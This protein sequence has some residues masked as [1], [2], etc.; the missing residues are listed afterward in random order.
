M[1]MPVQVIA[2][3]R[4]D[5]QNPPILD[6]R[7]TS[8]Q[9]EKHTLTLRV[10]SMCA[11]GAGVVRLIKEIIGVG[12]PEEPMQYADIAEWQNELLE[13]HETEAG[14]AYWNV[15][16]SGQFATVPFERGSASSAFDPREHVLSFPEAQVRRLE[17]ISAEYGCELSS[18]LLASWQ[19]LLWRLDD[20]PESVIGVAF[21]GRK[22]EDLQ[23]TPGPLTRFLPV[24]SSLSWDTP[25]AR[26]TKNA[27]DSMRDA[28]KWQEFFDAGRSIPIAFE[29]DEVPEPIVVG[30][31]RYTFLEQTSCVDRFKV[32][33]CCAKAARQLRITF[34]YDAALVGTDDIERLADRFQTLITS[35]IR[36]PQALAGELDIVGEGEQRRLLKEFTG[37]AVIDRRYRIAGLYKCGFMNCSKS[38]RSRL[39]ILWQSAVPA[40]L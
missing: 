17:A 7:I 2:D 6:L 24:Q 18:L 38:N 33:L 29:Y 19:V 32:K 4:D 26:A 21:D 3:S 12:A 34:R 37:S 1:T 40:A 28:H 5:L 9:P 25:F 30:N 16:G 35:I 39:R 15:R 36:T 8:D 20:Q 11:D 14:R 10:A 27:S 31:T 22:Y 23:E 13:S